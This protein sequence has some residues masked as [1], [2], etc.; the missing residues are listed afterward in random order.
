MNTG[1]SDQLRAPCH[2]VRGSTDDRTS[3]TTPVAQESGRSRRRPDETDRNKHEHRRPARRPKSVYTVRGCPVVRPERRTRH[4]S[5]THARATIRIVSS[6]PRLP[7]VIGAI[8]AAR[9]RPDD[10]A[11]VQDTSASQ[12][13]PPLGLGANEPPR[14]AMAADSVRGGG[15]SA[16]QRRP[17]LP[18]SKSSAERGF[19]SAPERTRTSPDHK[20]HKAPQ[21]Q[22]A[23]VAASMGVQIVQIASLPGRVG[24]AGRRGCCHGLRCETRCR[25]ARY[26]SLASV[27]A[28]VT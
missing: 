6:G 26:A 21:P 10:P 5:I 13:A 16:H 8:V 4:F 15:P 19:P 28:S 12:P 20:A 23:R 14:R 17:A 7:V 27:H 2:L 11:L 18:P 24:R 1:R 22:S 9:E 25:S 3:G